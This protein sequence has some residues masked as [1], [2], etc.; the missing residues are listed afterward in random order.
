[1]RE[2]VVVEL[3]AIT[4]AEVDMETVGLPD[5]MESRLGDASM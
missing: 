4:D 3:P 5:L 1:M 2:T